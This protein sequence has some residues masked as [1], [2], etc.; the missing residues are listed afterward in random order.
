MGAEGNNRSQELLV[1]I[2]LKNESTCGHGLFIEP[3]QARTQKGFT[4]RASHHT[5]QYV[6]EYLYK[7]GVGQ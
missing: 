4:V 2:A 6:D 1:C 5:I 7:L 3:A